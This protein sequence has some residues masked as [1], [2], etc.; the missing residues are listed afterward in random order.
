MPVDE[1]GGDEPSD[2]QRHRPLRGSSE[3]L[4]GSG[5][6]LHPRSTRRA[7]ALARRT[8]ELSIAAPQVIAHR[9]TRMALA[10]PRPGRR[11][12]NEF[13]AMFAEKQA[14]FARSWLDMLTEGWRIQQR[15]ALSTLQAMS[16][17]QPVSKRTIAAGAW[18]INDAAIALAA[19][20][21]APVHRKAVSNAK[22]LGR[23][24]L[25]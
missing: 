22:R 10:G 15:F 2:Y 6:P 13:Y 5:T 19:R 9:L 16:R 20:G 12:R 18:K 23:R 4:T 21:L 25:R 24:R 1:G 8:G 17:S 7:A 11:D 14:A 3:P